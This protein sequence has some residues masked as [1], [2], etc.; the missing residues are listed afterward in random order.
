[1]MKQTTEAFGKKIKIT[2]D[3]VEKLGQTMK[4]NLGESSEKLAKDLGDPKVAL[5]D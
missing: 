2:D 4:K 1:M 3:V 5:D